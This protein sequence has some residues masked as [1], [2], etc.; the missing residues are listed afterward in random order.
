LYINDLPIDN[1]GSI[2]LA[3]SPVNIEGARTALFA[4]D[5]NIQI[6]AQNEDL[7]NKKIKQRYAAVINLVSCI[8]RVI[9]QYRENYSNV[10]SP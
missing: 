5:T 10:V 8:K 6:K 2:A 4:D 1:I 3:Y 7:L 9:D